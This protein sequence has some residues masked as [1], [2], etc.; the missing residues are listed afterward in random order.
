MQMICSYYH[1][2]KQGYKIV[3]TRYLPTATRGCYYKS[4]KK[5]KK[6]KQDCSFSKTRKKMS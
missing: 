2:L 4:K 1:D 5:K 3:L 6:K